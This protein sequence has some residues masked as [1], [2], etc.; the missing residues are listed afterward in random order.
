MSSIQ[1]REIQKQDNQQIAAVIREVFI[2]DNF[3]KTGTAFADIQLDFM[4]EAYDKPR[5]TYFVVEVEGKIVGGAGVS[6][7]E[8]S[9]ENI[10]ELQKMYFLQEV[11][12]KG[13]GSQMIQKCLE[14]ATELGYEKCYLETLPEMLAAQSLYKKMGFEYLCAPLGNTGHTT[15]PVWMIKSL[16]SK[17]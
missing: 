15:C 12:G 2:A 5:A 7:L 8:N 10:C 14:K 9:T 11:R 1:I 17:S 6:Q 16:N 13:I 3:P 4:F